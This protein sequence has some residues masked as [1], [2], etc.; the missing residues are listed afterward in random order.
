LK[1]TALGAFHTTIGI[2]SLPGGLIA[3]WLWDNYGSNATYWFGSGASVLAVLLLWNMIK[4]EMP[5]SVSK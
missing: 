5:K 2:V 4:N 3:G 1:A